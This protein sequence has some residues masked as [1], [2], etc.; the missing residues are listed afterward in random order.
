MILVRKVEKHEG[1]KCGGKT[2][3]EKRSREAAGMNRKDRRNSPELAASV[4]PPRV[5]PDEPTEPS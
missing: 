3:T 2:K 4:S 5:N 1:D